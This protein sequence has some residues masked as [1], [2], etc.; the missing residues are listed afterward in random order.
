MLH[1]RD[2][3]DT[4]RSRGRQ[5]FVRF[6]PGQILLAARPEGINGAAG[7]VAKRGMCRGVT[8]NSVNLARGEER[9][10]KRGEQQVDVVWREALWVMA[11]AF[12]SVIAHLRVVV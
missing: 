1:D 8:Q 3:D 11:I 12:D 7:A 9:G 4:Q 10:E 2:I 6:A 5:V